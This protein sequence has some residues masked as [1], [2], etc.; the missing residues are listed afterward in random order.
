MVCLIPL[1][2]SE[3]FS[4]LRISTRPFTM[5]SVSSWP[6]RPCTGALA[7]LTDAM[8]CTRIG[9]PLP[10]S[11]TTTRSISAE[12]LNVPSERTRNCWRPCAI[13]PPPALALACANAENSCASVILAS[14]IFARSG[15]T[16]YCLS[17][18]PMETTLAT[19]GTFLRAFSTTHSSI[20]RN[21]REL[22]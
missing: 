6:T 15:F 21:W 7:S 20:S 2:S 3:G 5:S 22:R 11:P 13:A 14:R 18:P 9:T 17:A 10:L 16:S 19:P 12:V 4:P 8:S 1:S